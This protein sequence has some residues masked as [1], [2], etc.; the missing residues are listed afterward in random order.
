MGSK[1]KVLV[2][3]SGGVDSSVAAYLLKEQGYEVIGATMQQW[4]NDAPL[5][6]GETGCCSLSAV[7]DARRV[8]H[9]L[10]IPHYVL[11]YKAQ[12]EEQVIQYFIREYLQGRTPNPCMACNRVYRF[13]A[14]LRKADELGIDYVAT[15]HYAR[16][17]YDESRQR[18]V[19]AKGKDHNKDQSYFLYG[20]TQA[21]MARTLLPVG[22]YTKPEI[23]EIA[24]RIGLPTA[25][26]P[27]SQEIC[28]I[29]D[30]DYR[31][32]LRDRVGMK[33]EPG[34]FLDET[35]RRVGT[36]QGIACYTI[37]QRKGLGLALGT[38]VY[39]VDIDP[40][41]NAVI[42]GPEASLYS[43]GLVAGQNNYILVDTLTQ[44]L[45]V[46]VKIRYR[47]PLV[48]AYLEPEQDRVRVTFAEP[49]KAVTPGQAVVYYLGDLV[50]G[51]GVIEG[52]WN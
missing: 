1:P 30:N 14:L 18:Y 44:P 12:F 16:I 22:E 51:G 50:L 31:R 42:V 2:A 25:R 36:H 45:E 33:L 17:Y 13:G 5:P 27:E 23:R 19:L 8:A 20:F 38:P 10:D 11:N 37:G 32:F 41:R 24:G 39:V 7:E 15:G 28:F 52:K 9:K 43:K 34:P 26:K 48:P 6:E 40:K 4:P 46:T 35:G 49:Q 21:Q 47:A 3:M 29:P